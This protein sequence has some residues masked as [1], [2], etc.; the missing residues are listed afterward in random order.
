MK[1][2]MALERN[3]YKFPICV[4]PTSAELAKK[5]GVSETTIRNAASKKYDDPWQEGRYIRVDFDEGE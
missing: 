2:W 5:M 4:A 3:K 1:M